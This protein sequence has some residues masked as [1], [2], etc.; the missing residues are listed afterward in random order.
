MNVALIIIIFNAHHIKASKED[1]NLIST[2]G[3]ISKSR[4]IRYDCKLDLSFGT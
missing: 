2:D 4:N 3:F 1:F